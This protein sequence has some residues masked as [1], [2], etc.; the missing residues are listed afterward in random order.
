M[1]Q[2]EFQH[3]MSNVIRYDTFLYIFLLTVFIIMHQNTNSNCE[4]VL[5]KK[6]DSDQGTS[7]SKLH[8]WSI[9]CTDTRRGGAAILNGGGGV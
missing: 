6:L 2:A 5:G 4:K 9:D 8:A 3:L 7:V 1:C